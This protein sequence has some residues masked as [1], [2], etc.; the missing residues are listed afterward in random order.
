MVLTAR[1]AESRFVFPADWATY[2]KLLDALE[3]RGIRLAYDRGMLELMSPS[4]DHERGKKTLGALL[5]SA[6]VALGLDFQAGGS[7]TFREEAL[8]RGIEPDE[9]YWVR[10]LPAKSG[11]WT[12]GEDPYPDLALEVEMSRS[13]LDRLGIYA[14]LG[15]SEVWRLTAEGRLECHLLGPDGYETSDASRVLPELSLADLERFVQ[16]G[17]ERNLG[18]VLR[19]FR[20]EF[21]PA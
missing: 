10:H 4:F 18:A 19:E 2:E 16:L 1:E 15:V 17:Q 6:M 3:G 13:A 21:R 7:T 8:D 20:A 12:Q 11:R 9:C 5:E 14:A